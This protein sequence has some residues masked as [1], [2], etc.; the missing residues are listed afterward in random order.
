[1]PPRQWNI[2]LWA[3]GDTPIINSVKILSEFARQLRLLVGIFAL[4]NKLSDILKWAQSISSKFPPQWFDAMLIGKMYVL[5][6][7]VLVIA[8]V[9]VHAKLAGCVEGNCDTGFGVY[10]FEGQLSG[11]RYDGQWLTGKRSG[12]GTHHYTGG[13]W[14][15][16]DWLARR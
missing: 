12:T 10:H 9:S 13:H 3:R 8:P 15:K 2:N 14:Y 4:K 5:C 6:V 16:G 7:L 1:M 11:Q